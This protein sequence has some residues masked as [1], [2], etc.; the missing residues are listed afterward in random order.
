MDTSGAV[1][2]VHQ[3]T[4][5]LAITVVGAIGEG[6]TQLAAF[7]DALSAARVANFNLVR[8]SSVI[9]PGSLV[10][11][12]TEVLDLTGHT[13][14]AGSGSWGDRLYAVWAFEGAERYGEEAWAGVAWVQDPDDG[15]G[16]FV[17]HE[18]GSEAMVRDELT[19]SLTSICAERSMGHLDQQSVVVGARCEGRPIGALVIAPY[20]S[21]PW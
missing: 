9:P 20:L 10:R 7:D 11:P 19:A 13:P 18:G 8:L 1:S 4:G 17:E 12:S 15:R 3:G 6:P 2:R 14:I 21:E 16:L 5:Q